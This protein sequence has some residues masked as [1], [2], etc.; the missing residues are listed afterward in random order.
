MV[1]KKQ[2]A[3]EYIDR[4][5]GEMRVILGEL[6]ENA[7]E[8]NMLWTLA[9]MQAR[10]HPEGALEKLIDAEI[11]LDIMVRIE[12]SDALRTIHSAINRLGAELPDDGDDHSTD[13]PDAR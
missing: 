11:K 5:D 6:A 3:A 12:R 2:T 1:R 13:V 4:H 8:I 10:Q 9:V 7:G